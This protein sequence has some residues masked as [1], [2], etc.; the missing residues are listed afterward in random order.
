MLKRAQLDQNMRDQ[1]FEEGM[2][3]Q[4]R[5]RGIVGSKKRGS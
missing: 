3:M 1:N 2:R 4:L 5:R